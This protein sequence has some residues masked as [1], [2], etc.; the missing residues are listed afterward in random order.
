MK[1]KLRRWKDKTDIQP[2]IEGEQLK[3]YKNN[4]V[5]KDLKPCSFIDFH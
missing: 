2:N 1:M 4:N 5:F 3:L